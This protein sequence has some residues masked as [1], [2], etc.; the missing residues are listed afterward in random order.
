M[1]RI[2]LFSEPSVANGRFQNQHN[3]EREGFLFRTFSMFMQSCALR[4]YKKTQPPMY[5]AEQEPLERSIDLAIT[6]IGHS[7]FLIQVGNINILTDPLFGNVTLM[8]PRITK[9]GISISKLPP[10]DLILISHNHIDHM[11]K[12]TLRFLAKRNQAT[13][14]LVPAGDAPFAASCGFKS[15]YAATW[16]DAI[17][18]QYPLLD[19]HQLTC[20]FVPAHHW[21]QRGVLDHNK[22]LWGGWLIQYQ[23]TKI[24]FAGDTAYCKHFHEIAERFPDIHT[25]VLPIGPCEPRA[26]MA[27]HMD[28]ADAVRAFL[29]VGAQHMIPAHWGTFHFGIEEP[30]LPLNRLRTCWNEH[31]MQLVGKSLCTPKIGERLIFEPTVSFQPA[32][33]AEQLVR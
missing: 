17:S 24:Y 5:V 6:W 23:Q 21:S 30:E 31:E 10:I 33:S 4:M 14:I 1:K 16:W 18:L 22:S 9:P 3:Q 8:Y 28:S 29:D 11:E 25:A 19:P 15:V 32:R 13:R 2:R 7:T 20:T 26:W 27:Q 12:D